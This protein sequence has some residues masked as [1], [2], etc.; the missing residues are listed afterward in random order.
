[1]T[2]SSAQTL[3]VRDLPAD[4]PATYRDNVINAWKRATA[5]ERAAGA[6]WYREAHSHAALIGDMAGLSG[7]DA[8]DHGAGI[9]AVL[10]PQLE[11]SRNVSEAYRL[12]VAWHAGDTAVLSELTAYPANVDKASRIL[13]G[14][15]AGDV[16]GGPKVTAFYRAIAGH[17]GGPVIDRHATRIAT[18]YSFAAVTPATFKVVQAAYIDAAAT[19]NVDEHTVQAATWLTCKRELAEENAR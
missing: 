8:I 5:A 18:A 16:V 17:T 19:L 6:V 11:W 12:A 15:R 1:M 14:E 3:L 10:S 7:Q 9:L 4:A 2:Q 13:A